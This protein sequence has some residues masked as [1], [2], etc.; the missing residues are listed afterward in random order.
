[1]AAL[2][3]L[4]ARLTYVELAQVRPAVWR[5]GLRGL[6]RLTVQLVVTQGLVLGA[7]AG[8][9]VLLRRLPPWLVFEASGPLGATAE[10]G[11]GQT[12]MVLGLL[13]EAALWPLGVLVLLL[14][15]VLVVEQC[16]MVRAVRQWAGL[17]RRYF[18]HV[19]LCEALALM[20][21]ALLTA[22]FAL[23]LLILLL[24]DP[25]PRF[26]EATAVVRDVVAGLTLA[27]FLAY[28]VVAN[29]FVYLHLRY[30]GGA[31]R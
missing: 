8:L 11:A 18:G 28:L 26:Q 16:G 7:L 20:I 27:P 12:V 21:G 25:G 9:F 29:V 5:E 30:E 14:G 4:L 3:G 19:L 23:P 31:R 13:I 2:T 15:P 17:V 10:E 22:P 1:V 6:G 24:R